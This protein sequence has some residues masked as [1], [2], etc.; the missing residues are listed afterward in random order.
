MRR[1]ASRRRDATGLRLR[2]ARPADVGALAKLWEEYY[3]EMSKVIRIW[4]PPDKKMVAAE[5]RRMRRHLASGGK[6]FVF[7]DAGGGLVSMLWAEIETLPPAA[8]VRK[9]GYVSQV[10]VRPRLRGRGLTKRMVAAAYRWFRSKGVRWASLYVM[11]DNREAIRAWK[12]MGY[13]HVAH[14]MGRRI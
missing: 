14:Y 11:D 7:E 6:A 5:R 13:A 12:R 4:T 9:A 2:T 10:Y 3:R 1:N 8:K